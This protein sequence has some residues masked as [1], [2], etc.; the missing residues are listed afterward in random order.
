MLYSN[1][2]PE[3]SNYRSYWRVCI[4]KKVWAEQYFHAIV[5]AYQPCP[6]VTA[7]SKLVYQFY[8]PCL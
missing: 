8:F 1:F 7:D 5:P 4:Y 3:V 6:F 2:K